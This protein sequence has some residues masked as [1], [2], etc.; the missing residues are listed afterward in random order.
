MII[1]EAQLSEMPA[2]TLRQILQLLKDMER[3]MDRNYS[4]FR[5]SVAR[6][7]S[8]VEQEIGRRP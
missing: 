6:Q 1:K 4:G 7:K 8:E 5:E 3:V 2:R